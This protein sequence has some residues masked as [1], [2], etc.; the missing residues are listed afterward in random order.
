[1][2]MGNNAARWCGSPDVCQLVQMWIRATNCRRIVEVGCLTGVTTI[3][4][5]MALPADG[6]VISIDLDETHINQVRNIWRESGVE[7]KIQLRLGDAGPVLDQLIAQG[8]CGK[9]DMVMIDGDHHNVIQN[10]ERAWKLVR[11]NGLIAVNGT[12]WNG[13]FIFEKNKKEKKF[14]F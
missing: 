6:Q 2:A 12:L 3:A 5:A 13:Y 11:K 4:M 9:I 8:E 14:Y 10:W 7:S 1:M